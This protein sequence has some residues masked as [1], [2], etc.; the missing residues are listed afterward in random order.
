MKKCMWKINERK[1]L[2]FQIAWRIG[3]KYVSISR[4]LTLG[5]LIKP[6]IVKSY[7]EITGSNRYVSVAAIA[8]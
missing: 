6:C 5:A 8:V 7:T 1:G 2:E 3:C 4:W